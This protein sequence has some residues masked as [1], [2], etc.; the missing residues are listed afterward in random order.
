MVQNLKQLRKERGISQQAL[1]AHLGISQQAVNKYENHNVEPDIETMTRLADFFGVT[2]DYLV[3]HGTRDLSADETELLSL[4]RRLPERTK[5][6][7]LAF[8][9]VHTEEK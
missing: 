4:Y 5:K 3:G 9:R 7:L 8:E 6:S 2:L 1:A